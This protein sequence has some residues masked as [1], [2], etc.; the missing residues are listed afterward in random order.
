[1][2]VGVPREIKADEYRVALLPVGAE[3][4]VGGP[5]VSEVSDWRGFLA[6]EEAGDVLHRIR[7]H[8]HTGRPLGGPDFVADIERRLGRI[9]APCK[10][11]PRP[12]AQAG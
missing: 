5:L 4:L 9:L 6:G 7:R 8:A 11:G 2:I 10:P 12:H 1:M 3:L